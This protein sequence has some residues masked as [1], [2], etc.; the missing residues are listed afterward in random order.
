MANNLLQLNTE[1]TEV[2]IIT[3]DS[4]TAR[5]QEHL[6]PLKNHIHSNIRNLGVQSD[7]SMHLSHY[8]ETVFFHLRN[9]AKLRSIVSH[10]QLE[11]SIHAFVSSRLDYCNSLFTCLNQSS[12]DR[13]QL[14]QNAGARVLTRSKKSCHITPIL[15]TL[16]WLPVPYRIQ[17]KVLLLTYKAIHGLAPSY[18]SDIIHHHTPSRSLRS[19]DKGLL[20]VPRTWLKTK[21]DR[22]F[23]AVAPRLWNALP[24]ELRSAQSVVT[25]KGQ[26]KTHLY[27]V[28]FKC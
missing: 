17:Y 19:A 15:A 21:G 9:I 3:S 22:S 28:A 2:L 5:A 8:P 6:G 23:G 26:F 10:P 25:F 24:L 11:M 14:I 7:Q 18:I 1:K 12:I 16:H 27:K 20:S 13:L 4:M